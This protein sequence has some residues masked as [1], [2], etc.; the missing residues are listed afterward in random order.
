MEL[1]GILYTAK[2]QWGQNSKRHIYSKGHEYEFKD[3][4]HYLHNCQLEHQEATYRLRR[5]HI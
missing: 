1:I 3:A 4:R 2:R 5:I